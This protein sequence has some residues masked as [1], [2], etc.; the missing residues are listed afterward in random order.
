MQPNEVLLLLK[1]RDRS[2]SI[3]LLKWQFSV[4]LYASQSDS[5]IFNVGLPQMMHAQRSHA[6]NIYWCP[7]RLWNT[8]LALFLVWL[9]YILL[10]F[11]QDIT[12]CL[13]AS[14]TRHRCPK[15]GTIAMN[16][17]RLFS[18]DL[19]GNINEQVLKCAERLGILGYLI[20]TN[21]Q[22]MTWWKGYV[23]DHRP[24]KET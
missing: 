17:P 22:L 16:W 9:I 23:K 10:S 3:L 5:Q 18:V 15:W 6:K 8:G 21:L 2:H 7:D 20:I 11:M 12:D 1:I 4:S 14:I 24:T 13:C 19:G